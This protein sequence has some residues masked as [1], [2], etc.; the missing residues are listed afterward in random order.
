M[1]KE[2]RVVIQDKTDNDRLPDWTSEGAVLA[3]WL[4]Q[5]GVLEEIGER[6]QVQR[7]GGYVGLDVLLFLLLYFASDLRIGIKEFGSRTK[8]HRRQLAALG[9]RC[10]LPTPPS[11]SRFLGAVERPA[12]QEF[13]P[14]LLFEGTGAGEVLKHP[15]TMHRDTMGGAWHFFDWDPTST[16]LRQRALPALDGL[17]EGRRRSGEMRAGY[18]G[19][20]RGD[21]QVSRATLQH[22][23]SG[24]WLGIWMAPGNGEPKNGFDAALQTIR[25]TCQQMGLGPENAVMRS[26][27]QG[28]NIP[29]ISACQSARVHYLT[30]WGHY[31]LL[32]QAEIREHLNQS[33]W[34]EVPDSGSGPRREATDLGWFMLAAGRRTVQPDG[35]PYDPV[36]SRLVVSRFRA[37]SPRGAGIFID[38]WHYEL[39]AT[40][41]EEEPWPAAEVV[42][43]YYGRCGQENRFAQENR[44]LDLNRIFSYHVP[45][46]EFANLVGLFVWNLR[47]CLGSKLADPPRELPAQEPRAS[48]AIEDPVKIPI[49]SSI[50]GQEEGA[51]EETSTTASMVKTPTSMQERSLETS[52]K[53]AAAT[54]AACT[55]ETLNDDAPSEQPTGPFPDASEQ[56]LSALNRLDWSML[57]KKRSNWDWDPKCG[58]LCPKGATLQ[59]NSIKQFPHNNRCH[60]RFLTPYGACRRCEHRGDCTTSNS[61]SFR[62]EIPISLR[63][64]EA[65]SIGALLVQSRR[66][67]S[68]ESAARTQEKRTPPSHR[69]GIERTMP[70]WETPGNHDHES[71]FSIASPLLL[72]AELRR[73]LREKCRLIE[74]H[75]AVEA[76]LPPTPIRVFALTP[77]ERQHR[78]RSWTQR[79]EL[80]QLPEDARISICFTN[81]FGI[82]PLLRASSADSLA[83]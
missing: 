77:G 21:V 15:A 48:V 55:R 10:Q 81:G 23:G 19:R 30:R 64:H 14:W 51:G 61:P 29:Y 38:G 58:M 27:G 41:L 2:R 8:P 16:V 53:P 46:Q 56:L 11:V 60:L 13:G 83:A 18:T 22:A 52:E 4:T 39:F 57:L 35:S 3:E 74:T 67:A 1:A 36:R 63:A 80:N 7:E 59:L 24:L 6:L 75:V 40:D 79:H 68:D 17:P 78:R 31:P 34:H 49:A 47:I 44:E 54:G 26:D 25:S 73:V 5:S 37:G 20:K 62:K 66:G 45:G 43:N 71:P 50:E 69:S 42:T 76:Q 12:I 82:L 65:V 72:P 70:T 28:G 9:G 32:E 33:P